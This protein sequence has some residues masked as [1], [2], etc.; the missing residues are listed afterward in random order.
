MYRNPMNPAAH[1]TVKRQALLE[2]FNI[3]TPGIE[4]GARETMLNSHLV[5][6]Y[7]KVYNLNMIRI[8]MRWKIQG[9]RS[10][11][12]VPDLLYVSDNRLHLVEC[13]LLINPHNTG[14]LEH[15]MSAYYQLKHMERTIELQPEYEKINLPIQKS[16]ILYVNPDFNL[17]R[18]VIS[19]WET[20][21]PKDDTRI[22][23]RNAYFPMEAI[24]C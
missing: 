7:D 16:L 9:F 23:L 20:F 24:K 18:E 1:W 3:V 5:E 17:G 19:E 12:K 14:A 11:P 10:K 21:Y 15:S 6:I 4:I 2:R 13:K 22:I 8:P